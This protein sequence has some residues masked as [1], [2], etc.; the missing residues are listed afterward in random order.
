MAFVGFFIAF[1]FISIFTQK[2]PFEIVYYRS[3]MEYDYSGSAVF[4]T[5]AGLFFKDKNKQAQY[6]QQYQQVSLDTFKKYFE[7]V[8]KRIGREIEVVSME[9]NV[10]E[11][12]GILEIVEIARLNNAATVNNS[13]VDTQMKD[14][15]IAGTNDSEIVVVVPLDA[16]IIT[17]DPTPTKVVDNQIYWQSIGPKMSFP[18]V[19]FKRG[20]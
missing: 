2:P 7:D 17:I 6:I 11:R 16:E 8:S 14:L 9:S 1:Q 20:E 5:T 18:R 19:I 15:T 4:T 12:A 10:N 13:V 3:R